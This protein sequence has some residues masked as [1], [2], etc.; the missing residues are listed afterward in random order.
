VVFISGRRL[1]GE[2]I[3]STIAMKK[4]SPRGAR[5]L[6][7]RLAH[8]CDSVP[9]LCISAKNDANYEIGSADLFYP[10]PR[11]LRDRAQFHF[12]ASILS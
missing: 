11:L 6:P 5:E 1:R 8:R 2:W 4:H 12:P 10:F 7:H 3:L 9:C